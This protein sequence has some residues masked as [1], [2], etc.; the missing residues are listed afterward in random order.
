MILLALL[1][2]PKPQLPPRLVRHKDMALHQP[3]Q[4]AT[5]LQPR[6]LASMPLRLQ[7]NSQ[8]HPRLVPTS[9]RRHPNQQRPHMEHQTNLQP[10]HQLP[11]TN[12]LLHLSLDSRLLAVQIN[13]RRLQLEEINLLLVRA[14]PLVPLLELPRPPMVPL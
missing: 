2:R 4:P 13:S 12:L 10:R 9:L 7:I 11:E 5:L 1:A 14:K 8:L 3:Q 6:L